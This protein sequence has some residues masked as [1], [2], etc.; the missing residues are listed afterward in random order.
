MVDPRQTLF[1]MASTLAFSL[2]HSEV[3]SGLVRWRHRRT[4]DTAS[5]SPPSE[6]KD[7]PVCKVHSQ[8]AEAYMLLD[9]L[10]DRC[11]REGRIP[12]GLG[13]TIPLARG[14]LDEAG[15]GAAALA[16]S[17]VR[18]RN[19][20]L[21][22]QGHVVALSTDMRGDLTPDQVPPL[23]RRGKQAWQASYALAETAFRQDKPETA[24]QAVAE[25]PLYQWMNRVRTE[26]MDADTAVKE[27]QSILSKEPSHA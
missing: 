26:D 6:E 22:L 8:T 16:V 23:A 18:L 3:E 11:Q 13:G 27:L 12:P 1:E 25:D 24:A 2:V 14:L 20:A 10:A 4:E 5:P 15:Q 19:D 21:A 9:G 7:C 17:D